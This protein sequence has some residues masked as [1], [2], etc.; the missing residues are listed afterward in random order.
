MKKYVKFRGDNCKNGNFTKNKPYKVIRKHGRYGVKIIDDYGD[1]SFVL[2]E[3][4][5]AHLSG[6]E[7]W[8]FCDENDKELESKNNQGYKG[9]FE[10]SNGDVMTW[11]TVGKINITKELKRIAAM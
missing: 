7:S 5:C 11:G 4:E 2:T 8:V 6:K 10:L 3:V 9:Q 1:L